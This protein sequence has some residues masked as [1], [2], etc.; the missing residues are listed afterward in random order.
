[1]NDTPSYTS[2]LH[3]V[4]YLPQQTPQPELQPHRPSMFDLSTP[5][6]VTPQGAKILTQ[7]DLPVGHPAKTNGGT[8]SSNYKP[9]SQANSEILPPLGTL[10]YYPKY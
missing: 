5:H 4:P 7:E 10:Q 2:N 1:M 8:F 3:E 9:P 6:V